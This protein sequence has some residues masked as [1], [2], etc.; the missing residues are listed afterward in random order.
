[1]RRSTAKGILAT[2]LT[3]AT[4]GVVQGF[5]SFNT[6]GVA[7]PHDGMTVLFADTMARPGFGTAQQGGFGNNN[8][9]NGGGFGGNNNNGGSFNSPGG[10]EGGGSFPGAQNNGGAKPFGNGP[11]VGQQN[12]PNMNGP[13]GGMSSFGGQQPQGGNSFPQQQSMG[14]Q[15]AQAP[16]PSMNRPSVGQQGGPN[17]N[18]ASSSRPQGNQGS[19]PPMK[20]QLPSSFGRSQFPQPAATAIQKQMYVMQE[21]FGDIVQGSS[22]KTWGFNS[23][24]QMDRVLLEMTTTGRP[25]E[26]KI[27]LWE[28]PDNKPQK[29]RAWSEDGA[30][31]PL[32][33]LIE[34]PSKQN[35]LA[36]KNT[37]P[38]FE[39]PLSAR[40]ADGDTVGSSDFS[41]PVSAQRLWDYGGEMV[42][43]QGGAIDTFKFGDETVSVQIVLQTMGLPLCARLELSQGPNNNKQV[44]D[45]YSQDGMTYPASFVLESP[46]EGKTLRIMNSASMEYPIYAW[47]EPVFASDASG[48]VEVLGNTQQMSSLTASTM[49]PPRNNMA[50]TRKRK[51]QTTPI[52]WNP[53]V[54]NKIPESSGWATTFSGSPQNSLAFFPSSTSSN[55]N[56]AAKMISSQGLYSPNISEGEVRRLFYLWNDALATLDSQAVANR[57]ARQ[58]V[59]LPTVSDVPRTN[60]DGIVDYF[61]HFLEKRPQGVILDSFVRIGDN[62]C[63]DTGIYEFT[64][65]TTGDKVK[66]RY[67]FVYVFEG[68]EWKIAHHHSSMMPEGAKGTVLEEDQV[69]SLFYLWNDALATLDPDAV[70]SRYSKNPCLLPTVSDIPRCDYPSIRD[71]FV[72]FLEKSPQGQILE[73]FVQTG[74]DWCMDNGI[75]EFYMGA[76]G[77]TVKARYSFIYVKEGDEWKIAHHHS[78]QMPEEVEPKKKSMPQQN[79]PQQQQMANGGHYQQM[80]NGGGGMKQMNGGGMNQMNGGGM[81]QMNGGNTPFG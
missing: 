73:S 66:A 3:V 20:Q 62:W 69:R 27:E 9:N 53:N 37:G 31:Y 58:A 78:S 64:M 18:G 60:R 65:G 13:Q 23:K 77:D 38:N 67:S 50:L 2:T 74:P 44:I 32:R 59:L 26:A 28:G 68:G 80:N 70:A 5:N 81:N 14:G 4:Y 49:G 79:M 12:G 61:N 76:T 36:V 6:N 41:N 11:S 45:I 52:S 8:N 72:H 22:I 7:R 25:L 57:Y 46:G 29:I 75:Y 55:Q 54:S 42:N 15:L 24:N 33:A 47:V 10:G 43:I 40:V 30:A 1:M 16:S 34:L 48:N 71:Y 17:M 51:L 21:K 35:T 63:Q 19:R 56:Y 39:F